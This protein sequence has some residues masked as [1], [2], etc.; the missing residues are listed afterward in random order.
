MIRKETSH[1]GFR[2]LLGSGLLTITPVEFLGHPIRKGPFVSLYGRQLVGMPAHVV[3]QS[4][5]ERGRERLTSIE[6][7]RRQA[8]RCS[9]EARVTR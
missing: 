9:L 4:V 2:V 6:P 8:E 1:D 5:G 7:F 3:G